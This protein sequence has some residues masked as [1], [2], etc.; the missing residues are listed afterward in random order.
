[1][2]NMTLS[3]CCNGEIYQNDITVIIYIYFNHLLIHVL[4]LMT[5]LFKHF[6]N[7]KSTTNEKRIDETV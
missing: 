7:H 1:M 6:S 3:R 2:I 5:Q 4:E